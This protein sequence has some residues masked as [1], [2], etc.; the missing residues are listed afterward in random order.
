M[1]YIHVQDCKQWWTLII[2]RE[3]ERRE[4][5]SKCRGLK[6]AKRQKVV[7]YKIVEIKYYAFS[8]DLC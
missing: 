3:K 7:L 1:H 5:C 6:F 4:L 8:K 2:E